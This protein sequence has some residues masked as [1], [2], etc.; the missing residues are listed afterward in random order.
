MLVVAGIYEIAADTTKRSPVFYSPAYIYFPTDDNS[1]SETYE[2]CPTSF[3]DPDGD[4]IPGTAILDYPVYS[5]IPRTGF[6][7]NNFPSPGYY[8]DT[9]TGCQVIISSKILSYNF[10]VLDK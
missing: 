1:E 8:A 2:G 5:T 6:S 9:E 7:C 4:C 3:K 10:Y